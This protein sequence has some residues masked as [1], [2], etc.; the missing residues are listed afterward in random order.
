MTSPDR[1]LNRLLWSAIIVLAAAALY[2][3]LVRP[4]VTT[5]PRTITEPMAEVRP[6]LPPPPPPPPLV[7]PELPDLRPPV[8]PEKPL[9]LPPP[10]R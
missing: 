8:P 5:L 9:I 7:V 1:L 10:K 6:E 4:P 3:G 2:C